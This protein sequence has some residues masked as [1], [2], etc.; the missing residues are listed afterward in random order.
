VYATFE[1]SA[2][3]LRSSDSEA[4]QDALDVL[5][6]LYMLHSSMLP[7][8]VFADA[9]AGV[10]QALQAEGTETDEI[11]ALTPWNVSQLPQFIDGEAD[12]L[13]DYR[14]HKASTLL[15]SLS[16][17]TRHGSDELD[18]LSMHPLAHVW[19]RDRRGKE[20]QEAF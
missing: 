16:L 13:D 5:A 2:D 1:A 15:V 11:D 20:Q 7:L 18:G 8:A 12:E 6:I 3:V 9:W 4:W 10:K 14:L 17:V 19:A